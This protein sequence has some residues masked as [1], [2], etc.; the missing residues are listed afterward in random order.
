[1]K[2]HPVTIYVYIS[3][4]TNLPSM[5]T[6]QYIINLWCICPRT[7]Y[8]IVMQDIPWMHLEIVA[9]LRLDDGL[10]CVRWAGGSNS[11]AFFLFLSLSLWCSRLICVRLP[12][13]HTVQHEMTV[14]RTQKQ[15]QQKRRLLATH[16][17]RGCFDDARGK[18]KHK[19]SSHDLQQ[20]QFS[21]YLAGCN[22]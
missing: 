19:I 4:H 5:Y 14:S 10:M 6:G 21:I 18:Q 1:M 3:T 22:M 13:T 9:T 12:C 2:L 15:Q 16:I 20:F 11:A 8:T 17:P 7:A